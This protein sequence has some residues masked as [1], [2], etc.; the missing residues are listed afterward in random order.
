MKICN[1]ERLQ[2]VVCSPS[3]KRIFQQNPNYPK[4]TARGASGQKRSLLDNGLLNSGDNGKKSV[5]PTYTL[6]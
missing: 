5:F 4:T 3:A 2:W 6:L 1:D